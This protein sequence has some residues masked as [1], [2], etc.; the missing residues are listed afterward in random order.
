MEFTKLHVK[1]GIALEDAVAEAGL[2]EVDTYVS[3]CQNTV[4]QFIVTRP[5]MD[6]YLEADQRP[7]HRCTSGGGNR[8]GGCG[9]DVYGGSL[10]SI[11]KDK[12]AILSSYQLIMSPYTPLPYPP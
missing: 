5:V 1:T 7:G 10:G 2:Q 3:R 12:I 6:L 9:R 4:T 11:P 8:T